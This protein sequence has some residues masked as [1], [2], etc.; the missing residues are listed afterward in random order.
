MRVSSKAAVFLIPS[1]LLAQEFEVASIKPFA[2]GQAPGLRVDRRQVVYSALTL[3]AY[4]GIAYKLQNYEISAPNWMA[5]ER[6]EITA[7]LPDGSDTKQIPEML[8]TLLSNRFRIELHRETRELPVYA[9]VQGKGELAMKEVPPDPTVE[10]G[11]SSKQ[12]MGVASSGNGAGTTV[13]YGDGSHLTIGGNKFEGGKLPMAAMA[14]VLARFADRPV[15]DMTNLKGKYD[16]VMEFS[17][18]DLGAMMIRAA[19]AQGSDVPPDSAKII[20]ASSGDSLFNAVAKLG[21]A[22][23]LRKVPMEVLVVDEASK[24]PTE[25]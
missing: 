16:F 21:L 3:K 18:E 4:L 10:D 13:N 8:K 7:K 24:T 9:L 20:D 23:E 15:V 6:W 5:S 25:N 12:S 14:S 19:V 17:P 2:E 22:L 1:L 11:N